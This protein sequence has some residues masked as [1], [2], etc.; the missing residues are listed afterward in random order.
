MK[1]YIVDKE[2]WNLIDVANSVEEAKQIIEEYEK[3]DKAE[4]CYVED[5]YEI[6]FVDKNGDEHSINE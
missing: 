5:Y 4:G 2:T 6:T 1:Y 3:I